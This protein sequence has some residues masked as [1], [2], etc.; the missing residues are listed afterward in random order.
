[1]GDNAAPGPFQGCR[2][3]CTD[4][5]DAKYIVAVE[6]EEHPNIDTPDDAMVCQITDDGEIAYAR[7]IETGRTKK[8]K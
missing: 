2:R 4:L 5:R 6:G 8:R 7:M 3:R 1:M